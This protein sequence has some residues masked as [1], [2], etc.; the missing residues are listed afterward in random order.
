MCVKYDDVHDGHD[1]DG[2]EGDHDDD[3]HLPN[4]FSLLSFYSN[5][6]SPKC[7]T[8]SRWL[9]NTGDDFNNDYDHHDHDQHSHHQHDHKDHHDHD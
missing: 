3:D 9:C 2:E 6:Q 4:D 7:L 5:S 1:Y 8:H